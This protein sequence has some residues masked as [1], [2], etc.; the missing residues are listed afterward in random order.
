MGLVFV[1]S[2]EI[3]SAV[4]MGREDLLPFPLPAATLEQSG[5]VRISDGYKW[6]VY[7]NTGVY[8]SLY[9]IPLV[10]CPGHTLSSA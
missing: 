10:I 1:H 2:R 4:L 6:L 5:P 9:V 3:L 7:V 8:L